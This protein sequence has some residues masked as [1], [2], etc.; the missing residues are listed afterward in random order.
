MIRLVSTQN[1]HSVIVDEEAISVNKSSVRIFRVHFLSIKQCQ[2]SG[3]ERDRRLYWVNGMFGDV[4]DSWCTAL[5][6]ME[7]RFSDRDREDYVALRI[8]RFN[9]NTV[10]IL[11]WRCDELELPFS[12]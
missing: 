11:R 12:C 2:P 3:P 7:L 8:A 4:D 6:R 5:D 10:G 1:T 9:G